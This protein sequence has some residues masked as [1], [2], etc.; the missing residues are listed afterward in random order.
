MARTRSS[1]RISTLVA[2]LFSVILERNAV[3]TSSEVSMAIASIV[4]EF[5]LVSAR[6]KKCL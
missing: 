6:N 3:E 5:V 4:L 2:R 1:A